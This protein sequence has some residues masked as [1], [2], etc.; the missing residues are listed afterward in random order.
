MVF[1]HVLSISNLAIQEA[2]MFKMTKVPQLNMFSSSKQ[3]WHAQCLHPC[4]DLH[5]DT[6]RSRGDER[7]K[8]F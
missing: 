5:D 6:Q 2:N 7:P 8:T 1:Y 4:V 3:Q